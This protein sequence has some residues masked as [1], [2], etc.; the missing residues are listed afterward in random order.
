MLLLGFWWG[1]GGLQL[2]SACLSCSKEKQ[3]RWLLCVA[4]P[5]GHQPEHAPLG[6]SGQVKTLRLSQ[7]YISSART[8]QGEEWGNYPRDHYY[9]F[10]HWS[11]W[12]QQPV[13][14]QACCSFSWPLWYF[15][16]IGEGSCVNSSPPAF[17]GIPDTCSHTWAA[18]E[19]MPGGGKVRCSEERL[20]RKYIAHHLPTSN[21]TLGHREPISVGQKGCWDWLPQSLSIHVLAS[22]FYGTPYHCHVCQLVRLARLVGNRIC[23]PTYAL[24]W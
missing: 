5:N 11:A 19:R 6:T 2:M 3:G 12:S 14:L 10:P 15:P 21:Q 16:S 7:W 1:R 4:S 13:K 9:P 8:D 23:L 20:V 24:R 18:P 17:P 22:W